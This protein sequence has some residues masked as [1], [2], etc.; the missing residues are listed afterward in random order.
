MFFISSETS[1]LSSSAVKSNYDRDI[2]SSLRIL[3]ACYSTFSSTFPFLISSI[4]SILF[5]A[6]CSSCCGVTFAGELGDL[7]VFKDDSSSFKVK[8]GTFLIKDV[9]KRFKV[10]RVFFSIADVAALLGEGP[11]VLSNALCVSAFYSY[12]LKNSGLKF[13]TTVPLLNNFLS[14]STFAF[15]FNFFSLV[16]EGGAACCVTSIIRS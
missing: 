7:S 16:S 9:Y 1:S 10:L 2:N 4:S 13:G 11:I 3:P 15:D 5:M 6:L 8:S 12:I 14:G